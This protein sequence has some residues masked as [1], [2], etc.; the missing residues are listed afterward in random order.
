[1]ASIGYPYVTLRIK[2][3]RIPDKTGFFIGT[4]L[5]EDTFGELSVGVHGMVCSILLRTLIFL[6]QEYL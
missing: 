6:K 1:M 3:S 2:C 4:P 5:Q